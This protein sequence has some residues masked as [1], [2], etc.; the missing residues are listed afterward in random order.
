MDNYGEVNNVSGEKIANTMIVA[1]MVLPSGKLLTLGGVGV[2]KYVDKVKV[3]K[4]DEHDKKYK[5][6][7]IEVYKK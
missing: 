4:T 6:P 2:K 1:D 7:K 3:I 5:I